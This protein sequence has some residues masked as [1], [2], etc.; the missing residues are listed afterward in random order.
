M[1]YTAATEQL[2][3]ELW[4]TV[5]FWS[6][7]L[8]L[9]GVPRAAVRF[10]VTAEIFFF[11]KFYLLIL[12]AAGLFTVNPTEERVQICCFYIYVKFRTRHKK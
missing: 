12:F 6:L 8:H 7:W 9:L 11:F 3:A 10:I 2:A 5:F 4:W 1:N